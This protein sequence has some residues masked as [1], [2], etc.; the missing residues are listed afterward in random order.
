MKTDYVIRT[1]AT[2]V[3]S[4]DVMEGDPSVISSV[5][6]VLK[7]A[8]PNGTVPS[9]AVL[10]IAAFGVTSRVASGEIPAG[11]DL[12]IGDNLTAQIKPGFYITDA[13]ITYTSGDTQKTEPVLIEIKSGV[14]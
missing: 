14:S 5:S 4:L 9:P 7:P 3:L 13:K 10:P 2:L 6:A 12:R 11:W 1:G 8:G